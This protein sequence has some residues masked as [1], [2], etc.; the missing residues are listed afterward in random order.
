MNEIETNKKP[1]V[2]YLGEMS[3]SDARPESDDVEA[4]Q[5]PNSQQTANDGFG[6]DVCESS[7]PN[8]SNCE[9]TNVVMQDGA[10][11]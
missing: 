2:P 9:D 11:G 3:V 4:N 5:P 10:V 6:D 8:A 1:T 7:C